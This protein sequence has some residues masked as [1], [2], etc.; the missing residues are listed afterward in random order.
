V[1][2]AAPRRWGGV[3]FPDQDV[4]GA[5]SAP[6]HWR[7]RPQRAP[8]QGSDTVKYMIMMFGSAGAMMET[9]SPD[10]IKEMIGFMTD[11]DQELTDSGELVFQEG[12]ADG[13]AAKVVSL[14]DGALVTTDGP[15]AESKESLIG[16]W[17][18]DVA[19]EARVLEICA[20]IVKYSGSVE[21]RPVGTA[22]E[23]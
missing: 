5:R 14:R 2:R 16:F 12:L 9:A 15:Y 21:V 23:V 18:V 1:G 6:T 17:V 13:V 8:E 20:R 10:W 3:L 7:A 19:D 4:E 11:L 22:P